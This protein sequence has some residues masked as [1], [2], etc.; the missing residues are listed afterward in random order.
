MVRM[1]LRLDE[2][3]YERVK[4]EAEAL[5]ISMAEFVRRA[6]RQRLSARESKPWMRYAGFVGS[7]DARSRRSIDDIVY[8]G[9]D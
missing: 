5:G 7:D 3:E 1:Q 8:G 9:K 6:V 2:R 4:K